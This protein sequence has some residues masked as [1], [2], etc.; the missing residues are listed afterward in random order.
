[1]AKSIAF[2]MTSLALFIL[3]FWIFH[4]KTKRTLPTPIFGRYPDF[5]VDGIACRI[6]IFWC[7]NVQEL[8]IWLAIVRSKEKRF[9][10][11]AAMQLMALMAKLM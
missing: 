3:W 6:G 5:R 9:I 8:F 10:A 1:V 7:S 11:T 2:G 4:F